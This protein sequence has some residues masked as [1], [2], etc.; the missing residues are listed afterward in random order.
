[1]IQRSTTTGKLF[2]PIRVKL[3]FI[4]LSDD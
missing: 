1:M 3:N 2:P 4:E